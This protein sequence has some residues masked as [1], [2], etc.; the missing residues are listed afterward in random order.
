MADDK[1]IV[2]ARDRGRVPGSEEYEVRRFAERHGISTDE[3]RDLIA[4]VGSSS[5]DALEREA[6]KPGRH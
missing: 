6:G 1:T 4:R 5:C 2:G 3:V